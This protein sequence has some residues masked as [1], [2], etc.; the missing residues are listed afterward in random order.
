MDEEDMQIHFRTRM[1]KNIFKIKFQ[2]KPPKHNELYLPGR[3]A[4][5]VDLEDD[6]GDSDIPCTSIRSKADC[7]SL[8]VSY[9][10]LELNFSSTHVC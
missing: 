8:E 4:Y 2:N 3:M 7:P 9:F 6:Y 10:I 5:V 1:A